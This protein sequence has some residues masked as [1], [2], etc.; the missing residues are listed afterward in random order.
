MT[1]LQQV[2]EAALDLPDEE[3]EA[4]VIAIRSHKSETR[5]TELVEDARQ[6]AL[7]VRSGKLKSKSVAEIMS[8]YV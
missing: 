7:D 6:T 1:T 2:L 8:Q 4:L 3:Q 5:R